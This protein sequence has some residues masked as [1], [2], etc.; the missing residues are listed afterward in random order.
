M[1]AA[2]GDRAVGLPL[3]L[4]HFGEWAAAAV[5]VHVAGG[6]VLLRGMLRVCKVVLPRLLWW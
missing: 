5:V 4:L 2:A 1:T 6:E 3:Q